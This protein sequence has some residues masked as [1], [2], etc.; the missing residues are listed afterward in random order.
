MV[1]ISGKLD[2]CSAHAW[3]KTIS[4]SVVGVGGQIHGN[5]DW[6]GKDFPFYK[7]MHNLVEVRID[8]FG[9]AGVVF[10][11]FKAGE[12]TTYRETNPVKWAEKY[13]FTSLKVGQGV[14]F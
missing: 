11:A 9:D 13:S 3:I 7:D 5:P 4:A 2:E 1:I 6:W 12:I 14:K 8:Y 10:E